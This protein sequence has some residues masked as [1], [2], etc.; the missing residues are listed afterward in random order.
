[1]GRGNEYG[2]VESGGGER[3]ADRKS[4]KGKHTSRVSHW[5]AARVTKNG[6]RR[7]RN[8]ILIWVLAGMCCDNE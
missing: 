3:R 8:F 2:R 4:G 6:R 5:L 1:M 7:M